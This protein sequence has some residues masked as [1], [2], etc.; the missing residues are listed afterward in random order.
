MSGAPLRFLDLLELGMLLAAKADRR[1]LADPS[2]DVEFYEEF[3]TDVDE[4][5]ASARADLRK[6]VRVSG[7][8]DAVRRHVPKGS[9]LDVGCGIGETLSA[10][11]TLEHL[12]LHGLEY[13]QATLARAA[14]FVG[15]RA[16]VH[17]GSATALPFDDGSFE[18][19]T[20]VEVLEHVAAEGRVLSEFR[21][22]LK[23][24]GVLV[25]T[26]P[27]RH[28][29]PIQKSLI[30]HYRHYDRE[31][32]ERVLSAAGLEVIEW[33]PN[34]PNWHRLADYSYVAC[35]A[36]SRAAS[37]R[38]RPALPTTVTLP[39]ASTPLLEQLFLALEPLRRRESALDYSGLP[40][41]TSVVARKVGR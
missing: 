39:G 35:S 30:G 24:G 38:G 15:S 16:R 12:D 18:G 29:F 2:D 33:L 3:F 9:V 10:M 1:K 41:S 31:S 26:V 17:H 21:R 7:V 11:A 25:L 28:W 14:K 8:I 20:C 36:L 27:S 19:I 23:L 13:S 34:Y 32:L 40:T 22:V 37:R 4:G 6:Q 5:V